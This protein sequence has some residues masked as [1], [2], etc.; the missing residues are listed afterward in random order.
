MLVKFIT[1]N[2]DRVFVNS[3]LIIMLRQNNIANE[4]HT[5]IKFMGGEVIT[6]QGSLSCVAD[7]L[8]EEI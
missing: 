3:N 4:A 8:D 6:V 2:G 5:D 1:E 7:V